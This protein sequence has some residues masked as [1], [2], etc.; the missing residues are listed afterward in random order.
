[1]NAKAFLDTNIFVYS[2]SGS[3]PLKKERSI[4]LYEQYACYS[5]TQAINEFCNVCV[6]KWKAKKPDIEKSVH[7]IM[8]ICQ[9]GMVSLYTVFEALRLQSRYGYSYYDSLMLASA[10]E[11]GCEYFISEDLSSGQVI[12]KR[13]TIINPFL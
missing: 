2:N 1:M 5:S 9:I 3:D 8:D 4:D 6:K 7:E 10:L 12:E 13:L 11:Y